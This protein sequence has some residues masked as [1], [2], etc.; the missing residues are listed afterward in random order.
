MTG[1]E[2]PPADGGM[3]RSADG[4]T[5]GDENDETR[6]SGCCPQKR[7]ELVAIYD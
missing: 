4:V 6:C 5:S 7:A 1:E 2:P 3:E